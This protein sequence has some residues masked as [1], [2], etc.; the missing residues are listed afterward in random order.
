M[1][2]QKEGLAGARTAPQMRTEASK[3][4]RLHRIEAASL[5]GRQGHPPR[6]RSPACSTE[7]DS[8]GR[9]PA[10]QPLQTG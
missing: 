3:G 5:R 8:S 6:R 9:L 1:D 4:G 7:A 10:P 2:A